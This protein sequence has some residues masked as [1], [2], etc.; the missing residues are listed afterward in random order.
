LEIDVNPGNPG[1]REAE[2]V[3][4]LI[5]EEEFFVSIISELV[6]NYKNII[7]AIDMSGPHE[8]I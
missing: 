4:P 7:N 1:N 6:V 5:T 3:L 2:K 8:Y